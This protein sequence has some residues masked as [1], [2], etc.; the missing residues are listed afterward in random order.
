M[1]EDKPP[2]R[3]PRQGGKK[4]DG[5]AAWQKLTEQTRPLSAAQRDKGRDS[6]G[7]KKPASKKPQTSQKP[8]K[9]AGSASSARPPNAPAAR[10]SGP[11]GGPKD[12]S[13]DK[14]RASLEPRPEIEQ[15]QRRRL[16]RGYTDLDGTLDLHGMTLVE[17]ENA[18][19][20]FVTYHRAQGHRW[21]LVITGKGVRGEGRLRQA[22]PEWLSTPSLSQAIAEYDQAAIAHGG[23][24]AFYLRL[25]RKPAAPRAPETR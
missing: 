24:G 6:E 20:A 7:V 18:L 11:K 1:A 4:G 5:T 10:L 17:A 2:K 25:R 13:K 12:R 14:L 19:K 15:K 16:S 9:A 21:V 8:Q 22:L 3:Q 23:G